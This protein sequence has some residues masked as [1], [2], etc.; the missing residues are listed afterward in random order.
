MTYHYPK[1]KQNGD[2]T[3]GPTTTGSKYY[4]VGYHNKTAKNKKGKNKFI[5]KKSEQYEVFRVADEEIWFCKTNRCLFSILDNGNEIFGFLEERLAY[6]QPPQN[7]GDPWHGYP[8]FSSEFEISEDLL[9]NWQNNKIISLK[10]RK[11][12]G[13]GEL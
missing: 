9:D 3:F 11:K 6:F 12:I 13:K 10:I 5:L 4:P 1:I 8:V 2:G 7:N